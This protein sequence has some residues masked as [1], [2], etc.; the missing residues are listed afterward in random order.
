MTTDPREPRPARLARLY[1]D[2]TVDSADSEQDSW[3]LTYLDTMTLLLVMLVVLL[4]FSD[5]VGGESTPGPLPLPGS[6]AGVVDIRPSLVERCAEPQADPSE[7]LAERAREVMGDEVE[8][9]I[10]EGRVSFRV[11]NEI[12]FPSGRAELT[13]QGGEVLTR[14]AALIEGSA[15][16]VAVEGH[17]DDVP[18]QTLRFPSNWELSTA[19]AT[20]VVRTLVA[21]GVA[22]TRL[23]ATGY[24][25]T[26]PLLPNDSEAGRAANRRVEV[27]LESRPS[28]AQ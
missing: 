19:R 1:D 5:R 3:L 8:V 26:R 17:T 27:I 11:S 20:S 22:P 24:A 16:D 4:A 28:A 14:M 6:T 13:V 21:A 10:E 15:H 23:R 25:E 2:F 18:I 7:R 9:L 12:L